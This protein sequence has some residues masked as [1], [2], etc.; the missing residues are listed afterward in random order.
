MDRA[1]E[2][3]YFIAQKANSF[4]KYFIIGPEMRMAKLKKFLEQVG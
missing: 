1:C 3:Q 2:S 4:D